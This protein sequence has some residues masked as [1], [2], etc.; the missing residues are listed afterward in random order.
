VELRQRGLKPVS[1]NTYMRC[2]KAYFQWKGAPLKFPSLKEE[3]KIIATLSPQQVARILNYRPVGKT[4]S[5]LHGLILTALDT[6]LR[7]NE[8]LSRMRP[9]NP[10][11]G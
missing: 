8:L 2:V 1:V 4:Q 11:G 7:V 9:M 5:R 3:Q 10:S 6:G